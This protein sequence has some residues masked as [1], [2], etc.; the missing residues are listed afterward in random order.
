[1]AYGDVLLV[2]LPVSDGREPGM[3]EKHSQSS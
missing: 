3:L 2:S 1:M